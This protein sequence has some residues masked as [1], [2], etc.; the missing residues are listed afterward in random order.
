MPVRESVCTTMSERVC[1]YIAACLFLLL[2]LNKIVSMY[3]GVSVGVLDS[4]LV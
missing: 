1:A 3:G 2:C 4:M